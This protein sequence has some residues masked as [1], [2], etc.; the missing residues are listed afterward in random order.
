MV[1]PE[2]HVGGHRPRNAIIRSLHISL[3]RRIPLL[4]RKPDSCWLGG[5]T[6]SNAHDQRRGCK[7]E[8]YHATP[9]PQQKVA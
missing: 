3:R 5:R 2:A 7:L 6:R 8:E 9:I 4:H 1:P